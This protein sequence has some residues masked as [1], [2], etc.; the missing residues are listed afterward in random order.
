MNQFARQAAHT[1]AAAVTVGK[2]APELGHTHLA[3][4]VGAL[5]QFQR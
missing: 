5:L 3:E 1:V 2:A 4:H